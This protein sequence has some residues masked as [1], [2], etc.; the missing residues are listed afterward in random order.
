MKLARFLEPRKLG[1]FFQLY[2][3]IIYIYMYLY[4]WN[5]NDPCFDWKRP[6]FGGAKAQI[7]GQTGSRYINTGFLYI[8]SRDRP[9]F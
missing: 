7:K 5:P 2:I 6:C 9:I 4:T 1:S 8:P 3:Y